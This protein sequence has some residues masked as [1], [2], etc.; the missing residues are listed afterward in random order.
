MRRYASFA[1]SDSRSIDMGSQ[2]ITPPKMREMPLLTHGAF[3]LFVLKV[4]NE[5]R[6]TEITVGFVVRGPNNYSTQFGYTQYVEAQAHLHEKACAS[7][8]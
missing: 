8:D 4:P 7:P 3:S 6:S 5:Y 1:P 2:R